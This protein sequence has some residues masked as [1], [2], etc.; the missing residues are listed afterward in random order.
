VGETDHRVRE[1][2]NRQ[3][4]AKRRRRTEA[5]VEARDEAHQQRQRMRCPSEG[6]GKWISRAGSADGATNLKG[7]WQKPPR[8]TSSPLRETGSDPGNRAAVRSAVEILEGEC[9]ATSGYP[10]YGVIQGGG[11]PEDARDPPEKGQGRRW[12]REAERASTDGRHTLKVTTTPRRVGSSEVVRGA[13][14]IARCRQFPRA[15]S[16]GPCLRTDPYP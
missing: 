6:A 15:R 10:A 3:G 9:K 2:V 14:G 7:G 12:T 13:A 1:G 5:G 4:R 16:A 8:W 11:R